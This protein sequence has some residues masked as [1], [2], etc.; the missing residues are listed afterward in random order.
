M[1][2]CS[3][4]KNGYEHLNTITLTHPVFFMENAILMLDI[5]GSS[6]KYIV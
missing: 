4:F 2:P 1:A 3:E 6:N 5:E